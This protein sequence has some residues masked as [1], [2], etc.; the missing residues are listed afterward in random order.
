M[1]ND[2]LLTLWL[3]GTIEENVLSMVFE[4]IGS[5]FDVWTPLEQQ[6]LPI[7]IGNEGNLKNM[8]IGVKK[9]SHSIK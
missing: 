1:T 6:L 5:I 8:L 7:I 3:F 4:E 2:G 9:S